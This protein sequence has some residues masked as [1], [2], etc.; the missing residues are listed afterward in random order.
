MLAID[1]ILIEEIST[2]SK[3]GFRA[4]FATPNAY[5]CFISAAVLDELGSEDY[6]HR[7]ACL[8]LVETLPLHT[9]PR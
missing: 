6:P 3:L 5:D 4:G 8:K 7:E 9:T 1:G 2:E